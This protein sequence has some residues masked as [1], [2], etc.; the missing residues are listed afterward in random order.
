MFFILLSQKAILVALFHY[1]LLFKIC[2]NYNSR[3]LSF[4]RSSRFKEKVYPKMIPLLCLGEL[5]VLVIFSA[6]SAGSDPCLNHNTIDDPYRSTGYV[7]EQDDLMICD[8]NLKTG[9]YRFTNKVG[10]MMPETKVDGPRCGTVAPIWMKGGHPKSTAEG[11]VSR[12]ACINFRN[13]FGGCLPMSMKAKMCNDS[14][15]VYY[16]RPP[17]GCH[18]AYCAGS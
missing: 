2:L 5:L 13:T 10:G 4:L 9:W 8:D 16:L 3:D 6:L 7:P 17:Y 14:F 1:S 15:Y 18:M 12:T 11:I